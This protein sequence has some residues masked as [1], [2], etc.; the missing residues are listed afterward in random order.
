M[1]DGGDHG[2]DRVA[3]I[4]RLEHGLACHLVDE[5][6]GRDLLRLV[7]GPPPFVVQATHE[8]GKLGAEVRRLLGG[9][10]VTQRVQNGAQDLVADAA[11]LLAQSLSD[12]PQPPVGLLHGGVDDVEMIC[13]CHHGHL[14]MVDGRLTTACATRG[15]PIHPRVTRSEPDHH[16]ECARPGGRPSRLAA[17]EPGPVA[18]RRPGSAA[19]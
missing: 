7:P 5:L 2:L 11:I 14:S 9:E 6:V 16:F 12:V 15:C 8:H 10:P 18:G 4:L 19:G 1:A 17:A 13:R 3:R